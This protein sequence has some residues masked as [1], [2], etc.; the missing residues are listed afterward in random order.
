MCSGGG[1]E[2][3][4][5]GWTV[6][7][8]VVVRKG[9]GLAVETRRGESMTACPMARSI[10][11]HSSDSTDA[12]PTL[13]STQ[14]PL[15]LQGT[16]LIP[17]LSLLTLGLYRPPLLLH[18]SPLSQSPMPNFTPSPFIPLPLSPLA[19]SSLVLYKS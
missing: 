8:L 2:G 10:L 1:G 15:L 9:E 12:A 3:G 13:N 19:L 18:S 4:E 5:G 11:L 16:I 7:V 17:L 6:V 14:H